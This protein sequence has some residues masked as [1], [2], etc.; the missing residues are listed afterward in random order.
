MHA[1]ANL[2]FVNTQIWT[3]ESSSQIKMRRKHLSTFGHKG[4]AFQNFYFKLT[5]K[6]NCVGLKKILDLALCLHHSATK[7]QHFIFLLNQ[8]Q[9]LFDLPHVWKEVVSEANTWRG[10]W[11]IEASVRLCTLTHQAEEVKER[12]I[13]KYG[14]MSREW[15]SAQCHTR[16][17]RLLQPA[18]DR[19]QGSWIGHTFICK[20]I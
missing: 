7:P 2:K 16:L 20:H 13:S 11:P 19:H 15:E 8:T 12:L 1:Y 5:N 6:K 4:P 14:R 3:M 18:V 9:H 17:Q 10:V